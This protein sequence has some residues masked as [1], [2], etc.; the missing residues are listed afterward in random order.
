[1]RPSAYAI[2]SLMKG[3]NLRA[4]YTIVELMIVLA[5]SGGLIVGVM[6]SFNGQQ[7]RTEF[8]QAVRDFD[9]KLQDIMNDV[10]TGYYKNSGNFSC[11]AAGSSPPSISSIAAE[12]GTNK[13][14]IF[15]G[16]VIQLGVSGVGG[17]LPENVYAIYTV[18]GRQYVTGTSGPIVSTLIQA[19]P[20]SNDLTNQLVEEHSFNNGI[21]IESVKYTK[22][23]GTEQR[24]NA[25]GIYSTFGSATVSGKVNVNL[26]PIII[27]GTPDTY[28]SASSTKVNTVNAIRTPAVTAGNPKDINPAG[29]IR[30]CLKSESGNQRALITLGGSSRASGTTLVKGGSTL[31]TS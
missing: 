27:A 24:D 30:I 18:V 20:T 14:C 8:D 4:G 19:Q 25:F 13:G 21:K 5:V 3:A 1:M 9:S 12:Q 7:G 23:D 10:S 22:S 2:L 11:T 16:K 29:G 17:A 28:I 31:C 6:R 15:V 26:L